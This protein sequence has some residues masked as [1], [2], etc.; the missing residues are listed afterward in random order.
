MSME[1][2]MGSVSN[3]ET[4]KGVKTTEKNAEFL[5]RMSDIEREMKSRSYLTK[6]NS[7]TGVEKGSGSSKFDKTKQEFLKTTKETLTHPS[8]YIKGTV[9]SGLVAAG[10]FASFETGAL[11]W[12]VIFPLMDRAGATNA[13]LMDTIKAADLTTLVATV[14][15]IGLTV[16]NGIKSVIQS[17]KS[18]FATS[19]K[20]QR[21][22]GMVAG[23]MEEG[24]AKKVVNSEADEIGGFKRT[25]EDLYHS[26][27]KDSRYG[28]KYTEMKEE[29]KQKITE[30]RAKLDAMDLPRID[31]EK[32]F[33]SK[34]NII[35]PKNNK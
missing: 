17:V 4:I 13:Q 29:D 25:G 23:G 34:K 19:A 20:M 28:R 5:G 11:D 32:Y 7:D 31:R 2:K 21:Y 6:V 33:D 27:E 8:K 12:D 9:I 16:R 35:E 18:R 3:A 24:L 15:A 14:G 1:N 22:I 10:L 26:N 30:V